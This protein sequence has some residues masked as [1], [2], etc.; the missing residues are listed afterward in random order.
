MSP[1]Q[2]YNSK[3][4]LSDTDLGFNFDIPTF[5]DAGQYESEL[6]YTGTIGTATKKALGC[7]KMKF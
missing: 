4:A 6:K 7:L 2:N 5:A 1:T 3:M